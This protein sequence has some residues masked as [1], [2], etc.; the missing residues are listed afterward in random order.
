MF[1]P[2]GRRKNFTITNSSLNDTW[3][4]LLL[5]SLNDSYFGFLRNVLTSYKLL[6]SKMMFVT[7][8]GLLTLINYLKRISIKLTK[9]IKEHDIT[10][11]IY[12][13]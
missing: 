5:F 3:L 9:I 8:L 4:E 10:N 1:L 6:S 13:I 11:V 7:D 2:G 12:M